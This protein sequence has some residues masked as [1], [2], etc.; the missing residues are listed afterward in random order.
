MCSLTLIATTIAS[1]PEFKLEQEVLHGDLQTFHS[2]LVYMHKRT[3]KLD[4]RSYG[5]SKNVSH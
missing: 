3:P 4:P 1:P 2:G 5:I